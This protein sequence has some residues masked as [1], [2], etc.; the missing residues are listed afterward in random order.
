MA[1]LRGERTRNFEETFLPELA[2]ITQAGGAYNNANLADV[3]DQSLQRFNDPYDEAITQLRYGD[4][5]RERGAQ[6]RALQGLQ[7]AHAIENV[8]HDARQQDAQQATRADLSADFS[9]AD[10]YQQ[11]L[12]NTGLRG[13]R[14]EST[15]TQTTKTKSSP[16]Q[17]AARVGM[18]AAGVITSNPALVSAGLGGFGGE[19]AGQGVLDATGKIGTVIKNT[20]SPTAP[21]TI[22]GYDA[23]SIPS[24]TA[25]YRGGGYG[26]PQGFYR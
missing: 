24:T 8:I 20:L 13:Q 2:A 17:A 25:T 3:A 12:N 5:V 22:G 26:P 11:F 19:G 7:Q 15:T 21:F 10:A 1:S 18:I 23:V 4:Y 16:L 14:N 9:V 6:D